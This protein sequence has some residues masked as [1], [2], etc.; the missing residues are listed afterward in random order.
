VC[1]ASDEGFKKG[2]GGPAELERGFG[3]HVYKRIGRSRFEALN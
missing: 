3:G 2:V 1:S